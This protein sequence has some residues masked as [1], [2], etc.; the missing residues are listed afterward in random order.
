MYD[1]MFLTVLILPLAAVQVAGH[2]LVR[3]FGQIEPEQQAQRKHHANWI[4]GLGLTVQIFGAFL[5]LEQWGD[6][7]PVTLEIGET[8]FNGLMSLNDIAGRWVVMAVFVVVTLAAFAIDMILFYRVSF[9][10]D[11]LAKGIEGNR[12]AAR[13]QVK[14]NLR[15]FIVTIL[16]IM[17]WSAAVAYLQLSPWGDLDKFLLLFLGYLFALYSLSPLMIRLSQPT[18]ILPSEHPVTVMALALCR[19]ASVRVSGIRLLKLGEARVANAMVSGL[20]PWYRCIYVTDRMLE[21]FTPEEIRTILAHE[22]GHVKKMH[23][24]WYLALGFAGMLVMGQARDLLATLLNMPNSMLP[25]NLAL[26]LWLGLG[27][28][29]FSRVFERQADRYAVALTGDAKT[30]ARA[31][32]KLATVNCS[33]KSTGIGEWFGSHPD[34]AKRVA[35]TMR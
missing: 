12:Q 16:P 29:F 1:L 15:S 11:R 7:M 22:V 35:A 28:P 6:R 25:G 4:V 2:V 27:F 21:T 3:G 34:I 14:L 10:I 13:Q 17:A 20:L 33:V 18:E 5:A 31:L 24:W 8:L 19:D 30:F 26:L 23:L 32:E 9:R